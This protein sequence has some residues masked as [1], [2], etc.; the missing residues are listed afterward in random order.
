[1]RRVTVVV[2]AG[3]TGSY[4]I[5]NLINLYQ[6]DNAEN[7]IAI[8]DGDLTEHK[9]LLRQGFLV[10]DL[11]KFKAESLARR[12]GKAFPDMNIYY[13]NTYVNDVNALEVVVKN[14][15]RKQKLDE[16]VLVSCV[17]NN[18]A[19]L[20][21]TL[22]QYRLF[23][24]YKCNV[25]FVDSGNEE[26]HGQVIPSK[27]TRGQA[28]P[29]T[30]T[31]KRMNVNPEVG[32]GHVLDSIF[33]EMD[34]WRD[35]LTRGDHELSCDE[36]TVSH[37]QNIGTNMMAGTSILQ[38]VNQ[39]VRG[40]DI[41]QITFHS[42]NSISKEAAICTLER[43][44]ERMNDIKD[45]VNNAEEDIIGGSAIPIIPVNRSLAAD[46]ANALEQ[47]DVIDEELETVD[48]LVRDF[49]GLYEDDDI[50]SYLENPKE[51]EFPDWLESLWD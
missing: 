3:G 38:V 47:A 26:W 21:M 36:V 2:G 25:Y 24:T 33:V 45:F 23:K 32:T 7:H 50:D 27:L 5:P 17:D 30:F 6:T 9:N 39:I 19:R 16:I 34:D 51:L 20:R 15:A 22:A 8:I 48:D 29:V 35:R 49:L 10:K 43:Y 37:P 44:M 40:E 41:H 18:F 1:M 11:N 4:A 31:G 14:I 46:F 42:K 13:S 12:Y 28:S